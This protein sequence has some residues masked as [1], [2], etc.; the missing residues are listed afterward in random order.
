M[1]VAKIIYTVKLKWKLCQNDWQFLVK[2]KD[3]NKL[4]LFFTVLIDVR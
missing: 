2:L 3:K 1:G 4:C